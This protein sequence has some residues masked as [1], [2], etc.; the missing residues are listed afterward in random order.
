MNQKLQV[1][2]LSWNDNLKTV[3]FII[4]VEYL[5]E[6]NKLKYWS[7]NLEIEIFTEVSNQIRQ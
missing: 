3:N 4:R 6:V 5:L 2:N 7:W 1:K